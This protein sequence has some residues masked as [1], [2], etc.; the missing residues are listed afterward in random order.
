VT[1]SDGSI[2]AYLGGPETKARL[3]AFESTGVLPA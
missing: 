2:G 1:R 3:L